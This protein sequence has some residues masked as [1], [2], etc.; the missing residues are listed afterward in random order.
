MPRVVESGTLN[1]A[2]TMEAHWKRRIMTQQFRQPMHTRLLEVQQLARWPS[3]RM[4][5]SA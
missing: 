2:S 3:H 4:L 1:E 5:A